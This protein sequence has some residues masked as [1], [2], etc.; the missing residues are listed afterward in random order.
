MKKMALLMATLAGTLMHL[1]CGS[2]GGNWRWISAIL[3]EDIFG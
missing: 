1:S 3:N 2:M